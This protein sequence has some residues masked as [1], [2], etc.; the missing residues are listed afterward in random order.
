MIF[1]IW[2]FAHMRHTGLPIFTIEFDDG[3]KGAKDGASA[4]CNL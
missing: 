1:E 2:A 3:G 4:C